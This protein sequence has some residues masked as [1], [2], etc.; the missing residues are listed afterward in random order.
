MPKELTTNVQLVKNMMEY[1]Q[2]GVLA[3][4]FI[5]DALTKHAN[6]VSKCTPDQIQGGMVHPESW[7]GVA[8]EIKAKMDA[9]Y[10][11]TN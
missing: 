6:A 3:Q 7:I 2:F 4:A 10:Q 5:I 1:S 9:F 11:R 8:K